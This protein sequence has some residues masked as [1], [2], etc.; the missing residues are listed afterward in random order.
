M[1]RLSTWRLAVIALIAVAIC[2]TLPFADSAPV[3]PNS[4]LVSSSY[5]WIIVGAGAAGSIVANGIARAFPQQSV[6]LL[7]SGVRTGNGDNQNIV[8]P[9]MWLNV[10]HNDTLEWNYVSTPQIALA[11]RSIELGF[12]K[13]TGGSAMHNAM[14]YV[15]GGRGW[16][17]AW[18]TEYGCEGWNST[19]LTP[20]YESFEAIMQMVAP[21][22]DTQ[23]LVDDIFRASIETGFPMNPDYNN[24]PDML[25]IANF[26]MSIQDAKV[27]VDM[28]SDS[29]S[30]F[31]DLPYKRVT[32]YQF[33]VESNSPSNLELA[34]G[35][36]VMN[37][38]FGDPQSPLRATYINA[39]DDCLGEFRINLKGANGDIILSAGAINSPAILQRSGIGSKSLLDPLGIPTLVDLAGVGENL[40]DDIVVN[41]IWTTDSKP[42]ESPP[43]SF[44]SAVLFAEDQSQNGVNRDGQQIES[45]N[46]LSAFFPSSTSSSSPN[47]VSMTNI[48]LLF[49]TGNMISNSWPAAWQNSIVLSPNVQQCKS[50]GTVKINSRDPFAKPT[51]DPAYLTVDSDFD[52]VINSIRLSRAIM[53]QSTFDAWK[54]VEVLPGPQYQTTAQLRQWVVENAGTGF[55]MLGTCKMGAA[56][57]PTAVIDPKTM[58]VYGTSQLRVVDASVAPTSFSANTQSITMAIAVK[59]VELIVADKIAEIKNN[60]RHERR[61][62]REQT[63]SVATA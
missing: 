20:A 10:Y 34:T 58:K 28:S 32:S 59:A 43:A 26:V 31:A 46:D 60:A 56:S 8:D 5:D 57:D 14:G 45:D 38:S 36:T 2:S 37:V 19:T 55:H 16:M 40:R 27:S 18:A 47:R 42:L 54:F 9:A 50:R 33:Y 51:I 22:N 25:G 48:E 44:L 35:V 1:S 30:A 4:H 41:L 6:L 24:G 29:S 12:A 7:E 63:Q 62:Q 13:G 53:Q 61:H 11:N 15:R 23:G 39:H 3:C 52:R 17:D 49:S 21:A